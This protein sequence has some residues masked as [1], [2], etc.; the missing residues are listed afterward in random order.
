M[1]GLENRSIEVGN[2]E[3]KNTNINNTDFSD[4][5]PINLSREDAPEK[6]TMG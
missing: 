1:R 3:S 2:S 5:N 4:T 6:K